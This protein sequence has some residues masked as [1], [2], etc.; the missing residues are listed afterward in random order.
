[1]SQKV[2]DRKIREAIRAQRAGEPVSAICRSL[3]I[4]R[5]TF[6]RR[7]A[8]FLIPEFSAIDVEPKRQSERQRSVAAENT[9]LRHLLVEANL[10]IDMLQDRFALQLLHPKVA[11]ETNVHPQLSATP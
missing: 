3:G 11:A 7:K 5:A 2:S 4:S 8:A 6:H 1:M 10:K 9:R